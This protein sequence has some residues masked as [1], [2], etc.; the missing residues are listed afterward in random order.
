MGFPTRQ[1]V[2][3]RLAT[4]LKPL[5]LAEVTRTIDLAALPAAFDDFIAGRAK[6]RT[7]VRVG[8]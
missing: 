6:G 7:V 5:H 4:D 1:R 8:A 3:D 2:W